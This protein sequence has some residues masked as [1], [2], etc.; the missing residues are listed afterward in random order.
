MKAAHEP[1]K[2][3]GISLWVAPPDNHSCFQPSG[4]LCCMLSIMPCPLAS[5]LAGWCMPCCLAS[6]ECAQVCISKGSARRG[7]G[8]GAHACTAGWRGVC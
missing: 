5:Q 4:L 8:A 7:Q 3:I 2:P 1:E 6:A